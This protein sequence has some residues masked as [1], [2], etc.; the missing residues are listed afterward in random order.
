MEDEITCISWRYIYP[1]VLI[2]SAP[3]FFLLFRLFRLFR[4]LVLKP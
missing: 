1:D 2:H 4:N 3:E